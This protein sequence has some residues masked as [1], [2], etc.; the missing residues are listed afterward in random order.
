[1]GFTNSP[2]TLIVSGSVE[3]AGGTIDSLLSG[4]VEGIPGSVQPVFSGPIENE[5]FTGVIPSSGLVHAV[6]PSWVNTVIVLVAPAAGNAAVAVVG[7]QGDTTLFGYASALLGTGVWATGGGSNP[8]PVYPTIDITGVTFDFQN[9][10]TVGT[11]YWI[12]GSNQ[13]YNQTVDGSVSVSNSQPTKLLRSDG[14][15]Y[16]IPSRLIHMKVIATGIS[17]VIPAPG[18][19]NHIL[20]GALFVSPPLANG[21]ATAE[22]DLLATINGNT[23]D[24]VVQYMTGS[25]VAGP[26][27]P[28]N[29]IPPQG[30]LLDA[31]TALTYDLQTGA[32]NAGAWNVTALYDIVL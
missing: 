25:A 11:Q 26:T 31:N 5:L 18:A 22:F 28:V 23:D 12:V 24:L 17:N 15:A 9:G 4:Q 3:I 6:L 32:P 20:L 14:R 8:M 2:P 29:V 27:V 1:M 21:A 16:P 7:V 19:S 13:Y 30:L 10:P